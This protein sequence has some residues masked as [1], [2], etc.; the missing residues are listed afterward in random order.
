MIFWAKK[1]TLISGGIYISC[2]W[3]T[4]YGCIENIRN[5]RRLFNGNRFEQGIDNF[6][7]MGTESIWDFCLFK[8]YLH[9][10][11]SKVLKSEWNGS[12]KMTTMK[13]NPA[14]IQF[15]VTESSQPM[16][17]YTKKKAVY[18]GCCYYYSGWMVQKIST[19][20]DNL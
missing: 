5:I 16:K 8:Y 1:Y 15:K 12:Y 18:G 6:V 3:L 13:E 14:V 19:R 11:H 2:R 10:V 4:W 9:L 20:E 7:T 17:I